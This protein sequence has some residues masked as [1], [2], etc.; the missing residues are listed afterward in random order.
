[1]KL[2]WR[3]VSLSSDSRTKNILLKIIEQ[4]V[5]TIWQLE[6][7]WSDGS[8]GDDDDSSDDD[9]ND[10]CGDGDDNDDNSIADDEKSQQP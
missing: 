6:Q 2:F 1:M 4:V 7:R 8:G 3:Q 10:D 5:L 9:D